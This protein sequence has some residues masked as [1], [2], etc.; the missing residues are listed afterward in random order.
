MAPTMISTMA[1]TMA[2]GAAFSHEPNMS[3]TSEESSAGTSGFMMRASQER[4]V[5]MVMAPM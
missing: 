4:L 1:P 2:D 5:M 3:P